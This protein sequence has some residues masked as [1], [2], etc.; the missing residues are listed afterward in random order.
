MD[1]ELCFDAEKNLYLVFRG[2]EMVLQTKSYVKAINK[3]D[4]L[5]GQ[6]RSAKVEHTEDKSSIRPKPKASIVPPVRGE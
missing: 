5:C 6:I 3:F 1:V 2:V 4:A